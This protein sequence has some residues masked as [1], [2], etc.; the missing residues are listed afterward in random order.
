MMYALYVMLYPFFMISL[1]S[2]SVHTILTT[3]DI[4]PNYLDFVKVT[5]SSQ[6]KNCHN[7][8]GD[9]NRDEDGDQDEDEDEDEDGDEDQDE[10]EDEDEE[11][12]KKLTP[13]ELAFEEFKKTD[14]YKFM[15]KYELEKK[16]MDSCCKKKNSK[17]FVYEYIPHIDEIV[18]MNYDF[19]SEC[20]RYWSDKSIPF[21]LL[22]IVCIKYVNTYN[23]SHLFLDKVEEVK[24]ESDDDDETSDVFLKTFNTEKK[25]EN[26]F[27]KNHFK[28][29]GKLRELSEFIE[30]PKHKMPKVDFSTFQSMF[31]SD[32]IDRSKL[33]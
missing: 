1:F 9:G 29:I 28:H 27:V 11:E 23:R 33:D 21:Y 8:D 6:E 17:D 4:S 20:F 10:D 16:D 25:I 15:V 18:A 32:N 19:N 26:R 24:N 7:E 12:E 3:Y 14:K 2:L 5:R 13:E 22:N 31:T 30:Q